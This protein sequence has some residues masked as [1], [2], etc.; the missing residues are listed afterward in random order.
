MLHQSVGVAEFCARSRSK[1]WQVEFKPNPTKFRVEWACLMPCH[2]QFTVYVTPGSPWDPWS[3]PAEPRFVAYLEA[4]AAAADPYALMYVF[5]FEHMY[6]VLVALFGMC[7][8]IL[9]CMCVT[10]VHVALFG[11]LKMYLECVLL[12]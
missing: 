7:I 9:L 8:C 11:I 1:Y 6:V 10:V 2:A 5:D 3:S 12:F 4:A